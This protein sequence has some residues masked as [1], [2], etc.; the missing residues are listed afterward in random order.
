MACKAM[1][2]KVQ[3]IKDE[4]VFLDNSKDLREK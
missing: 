3:P 4:T 1:P 2:I